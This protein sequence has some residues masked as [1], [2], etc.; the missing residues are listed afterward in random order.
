V[1]LVLAIFG[2]LLCAVF[3]QSPGMGYGEPVGELAPRPIAQLALNGT[4]WLSGDLSNL[5][6]APQGLT[7]SGGQ[8]FVREGRQYGIYVSAVQPV[9]DV[10]DRV[11]SEPT[12]ETSTEGQVEI[13]VRSSADAVRWSPWQP[14]P[15]GGS[16]VA[17]QPGRFFQH[18][19]ELTGPP[20][21]APLLR[22]LKFHLASSGARPPD[23]LAESPT[24]RLFATREGLVGRKTANGHTIAE[25]DRFVALPS[26]RVLNPA[27]KHDYQVRLSY[28]GRSATVPVWDVGPW[29]TRDNYWDEQRD[30]FGDLPRFLSQAQAAWQNDHNGGRDQFN[31]WVSFPS[32]I[33]IADGT[34]LDD[35]GMGNSD[36]VDV[37]FLWLNASSP[38]RVDPPVVTGLKPE[39]K[40][41]GAVP[42]GQTWFF[43]EGNSNPPFDTWFLLQ[44]PNP[45]P[46]KA[47]L[48]YLKADSSVERQ[49]VTLEGGS[50][51]SIYANQALPGHEFSARIETTRPIFA[52]RSMYFGRDGHSSPGAA[53]PSTTWFLAAGSSEPPFDTWISI[54]NP[55]ASPAR[56]VLTYAPAAGE[57][58]A[59]NVLLQ[60]SSRASIYTNQ[61]VPSSSFSTKIVSDQ[62]IIV[63]RAVYL[64]GG[65]GHGTTAAPSTS[66]TWYL[67]EGSSQEG[68][69][70][71][72]L[73]HNPGRSPVEVK[74][75]YLREQGPP[76]EQRT[77]V[78]AGS[79]SA[80]NAREAL[81]GER[82]GLSIEADEGVVVERAMYFTGRDGQTGSHA[83]FGAPALARTWHLPEGSTQPPFTEQI[84]AANPGSSSAHLRMD[85]IQSNGEV[86]TREYD[87]PS[88]R[89]LTV[90]V[91]AE[92]PHQAISTRVA[93]D[94]PIVV[95]RSVYFSAGSGGTNSLGIPR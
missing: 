83:S 74:L 19:V 70:S 39:P 54:L 31:R 13:E 20:G 92:L 5:S 90:D 81:S 44:N 82:F 62:P 73:I 42:E 52:E 34:F 35:L 79:R 68:F 15:R 4:D 24:V 1:Q 37:T 85:F 22:A 80:I 2:V 50:R 26:K 36:W 28:K 38:P 86:L 65:A 41:A 33:D 12:L 93:S 10:F 43:A 57:N 56:V 69:E 88:M 95:E 64:A 8:T 25:R 76:V 45:E 11:F 61:D 59:R 58:R 23:T 48:S 16:A 47:Y 6:L 27:G 3:I 40:V 60:P 21:S 66:R 87:L 46:A 72:L 18:R 91:N 94:Q 32:S 63:E 75:S 84:L 7:L 17:V 78:G 29:N 55:G 30:L 71:W 9:D 51:V 53:A 77:M 14:V 67:A 49:E 89:R